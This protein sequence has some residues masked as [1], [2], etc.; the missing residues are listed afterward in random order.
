VILYTKDVIGKLYQTSQSMSYFWIDDIFVTG[1]VAKKV[2]ARLFSI[3]S[4]H[5]P[6]AKAKQMI[7]NGTK[8]NDS[9]QHVFGPHGLQPEEIFQLWALVKM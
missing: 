6:T 8:Y 5:L 2:N 3:G 4:L 1:I 9:G 7:T